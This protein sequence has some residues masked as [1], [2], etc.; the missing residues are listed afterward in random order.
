MWE[1]PAG[2]KQYC[3]AG[4]RNSSHTCRRLPGL[5]P[6][7]RLLRH[8]PSWENHT[9]NKVRSAVRRSF[10]V[11]LW[12]GNTVRR[13]RDVTPCFFHICLNSFVVFLYSA[14]VLLSFG[15][16]FRYVSSVFLRVSNVFRHSFRVFLRSFDVS[17][18]SFDVFVVSFSVF[19]RSFSVSSSPTMLTEQWTIFKKTVSGC[20]ECYRKG[21]KK[22]TIGCGR[23]GTSPIAPM[24]PLPDGRTG[25]NGQSYPFRNTHEAILLKTFRS[26][27]NLSLN[28]L[29]G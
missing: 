1:K 8:Q 24:T 4:L 11:H 10:G 3:I 19:I 7:D 15:N 9:V 17:I 28:S 6:A 27:S 25:I 18:H 23:M 20:N 14:D 5:R 13:L 12:S 29:P 21:R 2:K 26:A 16:V 22:S